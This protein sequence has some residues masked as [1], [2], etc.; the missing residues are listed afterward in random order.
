MISRNTTQ[1]HHGYS[2]EQGKVNVSLSKKITP[3]I[4]FKDKVLYH[5]ERYRNPIKDLTFK[6][7]MA[8]IDNIYSVIIAAYLDK[9]EMKEK[10]GL[11]EVVE[12]INFL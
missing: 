10:G 7:R 3:Y 2:V 9:N 6:N 12:K 11:A 8:R 4:K 1:I 5:A